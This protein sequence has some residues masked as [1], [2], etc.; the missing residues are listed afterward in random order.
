MYPYFL[1]RMN[2]PNYALR[3]IVFAVMVGAPL[4]GPMS[5]VLG[6]SAKETLYRA[7]V[8]VDRAAVRDGKKVIARISNGTR[9]EVFEVR[10]SKWC[11]VRIPG[12]GQ[13]GW[14]AKSDL[15]SEAVASVPNPRRAAGKERRVAEKINA[16]IEI[17]V[18]HSGYVNDLK[19]S[20]SG[21]WIATASTDQRAVIW[22]R[23]SGK[24]V[25]LFAHPSS[26]FSVAFTPDEKRLVTGTRDGHV[27]VWDTRTGKQTQRIQSEFTSVRSLDVSPTGNVLAIG[28]DQH[29]LKASNKIDGVLELWHLPSHKLLHRRKVA[30]SSVSVVKFSP[31]ESKVATATIGNRFGAKEITL[32]RV[33]TAKYHWKSEDDYVRGARELAFSSDGAYLAAAEGEFVRVISVKSGRVSTKRKFKTWIEDLCFA[34][35]THTLLLGSRES[36]HQNNLYTWDWENNQDVTQSDIGPFSARVDQLEMAPSGHVAILSDKTLHVEHD[37]TGVNEFTIAGLPAACSVSFHP[38]KPHLLLANSESLSIWDLSRGMP[39]VTRHRG[40]SIAEASFSPT[41]DQVIEAGNGADA[42]LLNSDDLSESMRF[43]AAGS[44]RKSLA[45]LG[46]RGE[47]LF[48][49]CYEHFSVLDPHQGEVFWTHLQVSWPGIVDLA[50]S[51]DRQTVFAA[52]GTVVNTYSF[53]TGRVLKRPWISQEQAIRCLAAAPRSNYL[54]VGGED[55]RATLWDHSRGRELFNIPCNSTVLSA[56]ISPNE[57][58]AAVGSE[59]GTI[60]VANPRTG[61]TIKRISSKGGRVLCLAWAP[62]ESIMVAGYSDGVFRVFETRGWRETIRMVPPGKTDDWLVIDSKANFDSS[63]AGHAFAVLKK[64]SAKTPLSEHMDRRNEGLLAQAYEAANKSTRRE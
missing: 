36:N 2:A 41:G 1:L 50:I 58:F 44:V 14:V 30:R 43:A 45:R 21:R 18:G 53:G 24:P 49:C 6:Q 8:I 38:V 16:S 47:A 54:L 51:A 27:Q 59:D 19:I 56:S 10:A 63:H 17:E 64:Q 12:T 28:G 11:L 34:G 23:D 40:E 32:W 15:L 31:D 46:P 29:F 57:N 5:I 7:R 33:E 22:E 55:K 37:Q 35:P 52:N 60:I 20:S 26:V 62:Q 13:R 48:V 3:I 25:H 39:L 9:L 4:D 42:V 61:K